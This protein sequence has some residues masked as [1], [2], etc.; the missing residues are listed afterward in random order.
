M[1][2]L[3]KIFGITMAIGIP[4]IIGSRYIDNEYGF[5]IIPFVIG[6]LIADAVGNRLK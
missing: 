2:R 3:L 5:S 6:V 4:L 1:N